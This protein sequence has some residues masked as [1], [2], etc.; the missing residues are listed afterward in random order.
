MPLSWLECWREMLFSEFI[1]FDIHGSCLLLA[2]FCKTV[3]ISIQV[4]P[5]TGTVS[6]AVGLTALLKCSVTSYPRAK[7]F[8]EK[9]LIDRH[10]G[11]QRLTRIEASSL[12]SSRVRSEVREVS[13]TVQETSLIFDPL[14]RDDNATYVCRAR[15]EYNNESQSNIHLLVQHAPDVRL[16]R[17]DSPSSRSAILYWTVQDNGWS[18]LKTLILQIKN[19]SDPESDWTE[20]ES[21]S[22]LVQP[23]SSSVTSSSK[24]LPSSGSFVVSYLTPGV[25]YGFQLSAVNDVGQSE[26]VSM[27][28]TT[29]P[30]VPSV[31]SEIHVLAKTNE[32]ILV[33]WKR[34]VQENGSLI[35]QYQMQLRNDQNQLVS[36]Q[37]M[38]A[39]VNSGKMR[40]NYMYI[41]VNLQPGCQY[42]FQVRGCSLVGCGNWSH[43]PLEAMTADG[44]ADPPSSVTA[45]CSFDDTQGVNVIQVSWNR[46]DNPRGK[47]IAFNVT[48]E[49]HASFMNDINVETLEQFKDWQ[50]V[51]GNE[52]NEFKSRIRP[53]TN[54]TV[55]VCTLNRSGCGSFSLITNKC[56]CTTPPDLPTSFP[57]HEDLKLSLMHPWD[58]SSRKIRASFP[59]ISERNG[60]IK[61]YRLVMIRLPRESTFLQT[62]R[63]TSPT[64]S[65]DAVMLP[66]NPAD[67]NITSY[68]EVHRDI[69]SSEDSQPSPSLSG[70]F[71]AE[72]FSPTDFT[73]DVIIGNDN[74]SSCSALPSTQGPSE[75][76]RM[77]RRIKSSSEIQATNPDTTLSSSFPSLSTSSSGARTSK[78]TVKPSSNQ[79]PRVM[80]GLLAP[81]TNYTA[82]LE[83]HVLGVNGQV[84]TGRSDYFST[85]MTGASVSSASVPASSNFSE[86]PFTPNAVV[87]GA[88]SSGVCLIVLLLAFV[89]CFLK[90]KVAESTSGS[91]TQSEDNHPEVTQTHKTLPINGDESL[92]EEITAR[93]AS[94]GKKTAVNDNDVIHDHDDDE[95]NSISHF[96]TVNN[97][98]QSANLCSS[99]TD[100]NSLQSSIQF[101]NPCGHQWMG[102]AVYIPDLGFVERHA[103]SDVLYPTEF[104]GLPEYFGDRTGLPSNLFQNGSVSLYSPNQVSLNDCSLSQQQGNNFPISNACEQHQWM[105][106]RTYIPDMP[107][108][109]YVERH[110][111]FQSDFETIPENED[112]PDKTTVP[113]GDFECWDL[114]FNNKKILDF[115]L[116][117]DD[118]QR[119]CYRKIRQE[120]SKAT[121]K[122]KGLYNNLQTHWKLLLSFPSSFR[123]VW[124]IQWRVINMQFLMFAQFQSISKYFKVNDLDSLVYLFPGQWNIRFRRKTPCNRWWRECKEILSVFVLP[125]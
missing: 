57:S 70:A 85:V 65:L 110:V 54:Y 90:R 60:A 114:I 34:P 47:I 42:F 50:V 8:W 5:E 103:E 39:E 117:D 28:A 122:L 81:S 33:G 14:V 15:N 62:H 46:P 98:L 21:S 121:K 59:R 67:V 101:S 84:M 77:V 97:Q 71:I 17:I 111:S 20:L 94:N 29:P 3:P 38:E 16:D 12:S 49:G 13:E 93:S 73:G 107:H 104:P 87:F 2:S 48:L 105:N 91:D 69:L 88:V 80:D 26:W 44:H 106:Q 64:S 78:A 37:S 40:N 86:Y 102:Q 119:R 116:R 113:A 96:A 23:S 124:Q 45:I 118:E 100:T 92:S 7:I 32:T 55:R 61:C 66:R 79:Q 95:D 51:Q 74:F 109:G 52:S 41:F 9:L 75:D 76:T 58:S 120:D 6:K 115:L 25:T 63:M 108:V 30:D 112:S 125:K 18:P 72:E 99:P 43:P 89:L 11:S 56:M 83:V 19:Y 82:F 123:N 36:D 22:L 24:S 68:E 31:V 53:N 27:N 1:L 4:V 10:S 35:T